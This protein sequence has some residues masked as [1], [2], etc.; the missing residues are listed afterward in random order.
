MNY[1][2]LPSV[3][4][5]NLVLPEHSGAQTVATGH[6]RTSSPRATATCPPL[7]AAVESTETGEPQQLLPMKYCR[8]YVCVKVVKVFVYIYIYMKVGGYIMCVCAY[9]RGCMSYAY[10]CKCMCNVHAEAM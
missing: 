9:L 7:H 8:V 4:K 3:T 1:P 2:M 5:E 10:K 6:R